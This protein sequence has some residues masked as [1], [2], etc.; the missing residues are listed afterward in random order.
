MEREPGV[1]V[2]EHPEDVGGSVNRQADLQALALCDRLDE[3]ALVGVEVR[4]DE[5]PER[6]AVVI[7]S[8]R[9]RLL[10]VAH[11]IDAPAG[12]CAVASCISAPDPV[13]RTAT[14]S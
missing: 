13:R 12:F 8:T 3:S 11:V 2:V 6:R 1:G 10:P 4:L 7:D 9:S 14:C 5:R